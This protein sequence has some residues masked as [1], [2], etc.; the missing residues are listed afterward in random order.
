[1]TKDEA[2]IVAAYT[3]VMVGN[4][5]ELHEYVERLLGHPVFT[6]EFGN[7]SM[8]E[9]IKQAARPDFLALVVT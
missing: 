5:T 7:E 3:G 6:H 4:F 1:M 8:A 9:R 2:A